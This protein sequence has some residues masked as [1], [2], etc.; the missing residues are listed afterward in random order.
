MR[1]AVSGPIRD[2]VIAAL[3]QTE[4]RNGNGGHAGS[5]RQAAIA[6]LDIH[7]L[8]FEFVFAGITAA[9]VDVDF[10][11]GAIQNALIDILGILEITGH[12]DRVADRHGTRFG[13]VINHTTFEG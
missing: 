12:V 9:R 13:R 1:G 7:H 5:S 2:D 6:I 3:Q 10:L 4:Q 11:A 8:F